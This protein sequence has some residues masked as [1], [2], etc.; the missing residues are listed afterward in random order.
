[1]NDQRIVELYF[2][3]SQ[4]AIAETASKY[5]KYCYA[6]AYNILNCHEDAEESVD[7]TYI[8]AWNSIPPHRPSVLSAFLGKITRRVAIDKW[9]KRS[10]EK[11][12]GGE[13]PLALEELQDCI[14]EGESA[15]QVFEKQRLSA[16]IGDFVRSLP[17]TEQ[18]VFLCRYWYLDPIDAICRQFGFSDG[19]V[20][21]MLYRTREKLRTRL[22]KE[23]F[24]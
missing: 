11:R 16:V 19:K 4:Q 15:E 9:R 7:D 20:K 23:G 1:M 2:A 17:E 10:A 3:R 5:G 18:K 6:I 14:P 24:Q 22:Q 8:A 13:V 21:S 12:G